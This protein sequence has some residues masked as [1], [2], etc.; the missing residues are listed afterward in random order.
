MDAMHCLRMPHGPAGGPDRSVLSHSSRRS[1]LLHRHL[2]FPKGGARLVA[3]R[4]WTVCAQAPAPSQPEGE[5]A[6]P[7][8]RLGGWNRM[9]GAAVGAAVVLACAL[10][11]ASLNRGRGAYCCPS[12]V[13]PSQVVTL[14]P[15]DKCAKVLFDVF[16][17]RAAPPNE[18][19]I[20]LQQVA[21]QIGNEL[22]VNFMDREPKKARLLRLL[23]E[24]LVDELAKQDYYYLKAF[25]KGQE[26]TDLLYGEWRQL[27]DG[28]TKRNVG[29]LL[30]EIFI[31][32]GDYR[33]AQTICEYELKDKEFSETDSRPR[34]FKAIIKMM[35]ATESVLN[36]E[37][38][39]EDL[40]K[41]IEDAKKAWEDFRSVYGG[42][43]AREPKTD[44]H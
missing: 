2:A 23:A 34:F 38:K 9:R 5:D 14:S 8:G 19:P 16:K 7:K 37:T 22:D 27:E 42:E 21:E 31:N 20:L 6:N 36:P 12:Q 24:H 3:T 4:R 28:D 32:Q 40:Q 44:D 13:A 10:G 33:N 39:S 18:P 41:M 25:H 15:T 26:T 17:K 30:I 29:F 1:P 43:L 11:A 35:L